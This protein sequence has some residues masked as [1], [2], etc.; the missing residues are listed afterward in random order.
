MRAA[1]AVPWRSVGQMQCARHP[2]VAGPMT[3]QKAHGL[4]RPT[5]FSERTDQ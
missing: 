1:S 4:S 5:C 2:Q 3:L